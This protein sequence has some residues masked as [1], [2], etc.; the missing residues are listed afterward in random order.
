M[1]IVPSILESTPEEFKASL[2][3]VIEFAKRIQVDFNDGTFASFTSVG[4]EDISGWTADIADRIFLEAHLMVQ[5]P[6]DY[7]PKLKELGFRKII[8]QREIEEDARRVLE[9]LLKEDLLVGLAIAPETSVLDVEPFA[10]LLDTI[11]VMDIEPGKQG[12]KFLPEELVKI[13][14][15]RDGNFP[16]E[17]QA[18]GAI[19][20]E[21]IKQVIEAGPDTLV[22]GSAIVKA[23]NPAEEYN[24]L[25]QLVELDK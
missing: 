13:K 1:E 19:D 4:P 9:E 7:V 21:T 12:Q 5:R 25:V 2:E 15:L 14:E 11:T 24:R 6:Y 16:G 22:V 20:E 3:K 17:L 23:K 10:D 8:I 18:D